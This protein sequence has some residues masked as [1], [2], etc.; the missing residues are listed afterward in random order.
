LTTLK[1]APRFLGGYFDCSFNQL[2]SLKGAPQSVG[3]LFS[4][5]LGEIDKKHYYLIIPE[6]EKWY[7]WVLN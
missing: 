5:K 1:W 4:I 6:I 7:K 3:G 2:T